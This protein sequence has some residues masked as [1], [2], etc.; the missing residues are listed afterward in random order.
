[1]ASLLFPDTGT[2]MAVYGNGRPAAEQAGE[3][4]ADRACTTPAEVYTDN[5]GTPGAL[6]ADS[7]ITLDTYGEQPDYW[8]PAD[9]TDRLYIRVNG[10]VSPVDADYNARIDGLSDLVAAGETPAGAQAKVN[11]HAAQTTGVHGI[12]NTA[13]L[14]TTAGA[15]AKANA[16]QAAAVAASDP[17]GAAAAAQAAAAT[18]ATGKANAAISAAAT[19][20]TTKANAAQGNAIG[21]AAADATAKANAVL[22]TA[23]GL[24]IVFGGF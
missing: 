20:A 17:V 15:Q 13:L 16:A 11:A 1:M 14:E 3:L 6:I 23:A 12:A 2:R 7:T 8:G 4:F 9:G 21:A 18:D 5:G 19:D 24:A 10:V 22:G